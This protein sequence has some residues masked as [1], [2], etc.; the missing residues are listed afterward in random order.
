MAS[1]TIT[2]ASGVKQRLYGLDW[3][4]EMA[5]LSRTFDYLV[6]VILILAVMAGFHLHAMLTIGDWDFW[7]DWMDRQYWV[8][9]T[10]VLLITF[11]AAV[12][13]ITWERLRLPFGA[14]LCAVLLVIAEWLNR[15]HGFHMWSYFPMSF[16]WPATI[17]PGAIMLDMILMLTGSALLTAIFGGVVFALI[18]PA[19]NWTMLAAYHLPVKVMGSEVASVADVMGY[20]FTRT[21]TPEYLR[22]IERGTLRTFGGHSTTVAAFFAAFLSIFM[23]LAWWYLAKYLSNVVTV[24]NRLKKMMG[25]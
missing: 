17:I 4:P 11:P 3:S 22:M 16:I 5:G 7:V 10:P 2:K 8:T 15:Y 12:S 1:T 6:A 14:T 20:A 19:A 13:Y 9:I 25:L 23:Y 18:F 24:P 21:A